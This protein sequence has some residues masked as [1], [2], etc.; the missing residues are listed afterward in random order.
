MFTTSDMLPIIVEGQEYCG[1]FTTKMEVGKKGI[2][3]NFFVRDDIA[4]HVVINTKSFELL[5]LELEN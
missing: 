5:K 1:V 4:E 2:W 3:I